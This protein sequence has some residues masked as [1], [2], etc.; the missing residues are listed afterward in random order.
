MHKRILFKYGATRTVIL[1]GSIVIKIPRMCSWKLFLHGLLAN[2]QESQFSKTGWQELCPV[3][4]SI[5]GGFCLIMQRAEPLTD[6]QWSRFSP[7]HWVK[8]EDYTVPVELKQ[9]SFGMLKGKIVAI[10]YGN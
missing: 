4:F 2:M 5:W 6:F 10:D 3:L 9:S 7:E 1:V 8:K